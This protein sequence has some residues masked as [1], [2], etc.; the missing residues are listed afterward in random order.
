MIVLPVVLLIILCLGVVNGIFTRIITGLTVM[1]IIVM[2]MIVVA[3][4]VVLVI[5]LDMTVIDV[6]VRNMFT[7]TKFM[8]VVIVK[9][10]VL[11]T[12]IILV[13]LSTTCHNHRLCHCPHTRLN[14][15][16]R[17]RRPRRRQRPARNGGSDWHTAAT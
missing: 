1:C 10:V 6:I 14:S 5:A 4:I 3:Q 7:R 16:I 17:L 8:I 2:G 15:T 9:A 11:V 13:I 12:S